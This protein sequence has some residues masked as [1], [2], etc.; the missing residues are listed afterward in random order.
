MLKVVAYK[1]DYQG[2]EWVSIEES[3]GWFIDA[4]LPWNNLDQHCTAETEGDPHFFFY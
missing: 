4:A 2:K 1:K 3:W